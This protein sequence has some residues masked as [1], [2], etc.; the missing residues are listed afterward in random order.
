MN[1]QHIAEQALAALNQQGADASQATVSRLALTELNITR[2]EPSLL[3]STQNHK[4]GLVGIWDGRKASTELSDLS[5]ESLAAA[6]RT[7]RAD[8]AAAPQDSAHAV[9]GGQRTAITRGPLEA[10]LNAL[11]DAARDILDFR[12]KA[13]PTMNIDE[14][15]ALHNR[16]ET[17][18]LTSGGSHLQSTLGWYGVSVFGTARG[19][20][21]DG[22][23]RTSSFNYTG[24]E[25]E[26]L[27]GV[28]ASE[29]FG[30]ADM[31]R[32]LTRSVFTQGVVE[33][34]GGKFVG[35]VVL[36]PMAVATLLGWLQGQVSDMALISGSSMYR[37]RVGELVA[38]PSLSLTSRFD[39]PGVAA[40]SGDAFVTPPLQ[41]LQAG[42]LQ[43]LTPSLYGS[44]KTGLAHVPTA[45]GGWELAAGAT[46]LADLVRG[47]PRGAV[48]GRLSMGNPAANG[49][50]S[51]IIKNSFAIDA[52]V[53]GAALSETMINGNVA[54]MLRDVVAV[55]AERIDTGNWCM[56][57][58]RVSGLHFS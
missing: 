57:W 58:V 42:R 22:H 46:P 34:F 23:V 40:L 11:T 48:V 20:G 44:R 53:M 10:D 13:T 15:A 30:I 18:M 4:L 38:S 8:A 19:P 5:A 12:A 39:A 56:P 37:E 45:S 35:D 27:R 2:N 47:V 36:T 25:T 32:D 17:L 28:P 6:A 50:F 54:Q 21:P 51:G 7:L 16:A 33:C 41:L 24:G 52:G 29:R 1:L 55:S 14:G 26:D 49:D 3:R 43:A 31:M 9:S